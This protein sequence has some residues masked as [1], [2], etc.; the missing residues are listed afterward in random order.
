MT[1]ISWEADAGQFV[2]LLGPSGCGKSTMLRIIAGLEKPDGGS[3]FFEGADMTSMPPYKR[4]INTVFQNYAL[5]PHM[6]V[7]E[8]IAFSL[9]VKKVNKAEIKKRW[10]SFGYRFIARV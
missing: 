7:F 10:K 3:V 8:N 5:F 6:N 1:D 4:E 9:N 2:T